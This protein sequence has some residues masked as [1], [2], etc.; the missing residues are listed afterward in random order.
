MSFVISYTA[1]LGDGLGGLTESNFEKLNEALG[2]GVTTVKEVEAEPGIIK[3]L[4]VQRLPDE[5]CNSFSPSRM[6]PVWE[7]GYPHTGYHNGYNPNAFGYN[8]NAF[9]YNGNAFGYNAN[10]F[11]YNAN[12]FGYNANA[13]HNPQLNSM[14]QNMSSLSSNP[15]FINGMGPIGLTRSVN[16]SN[17]TVISNGL[18]GANVNSLSNTVNQNNWSRQQVS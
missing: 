11:G 15:K 9:G 17:G 7:T 5:P 1:R 14:Y 6:N 13:L 18:R 10:A 3:T 8:R 16:L 2:G 12:A 4:I